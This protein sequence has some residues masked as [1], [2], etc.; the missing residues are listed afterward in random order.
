MVESGAKANSLSQL[1]RDS[2]TVFNQIKPRVNVRLLFKS[3]AFQHV[4]LTVST[5][6]TGILDLHQSTK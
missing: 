3:G 1:A 6:Q 5:F 2:P 4:K